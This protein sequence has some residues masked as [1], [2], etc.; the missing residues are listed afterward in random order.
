MR[1]ALKR[2]PLLARSINFCLEGRPRLP[3]YA[4]TPW[5]GPAVL[6]HVPVTSPFGLALSG[7]SAVKRHRFRSDGSFAKQVDIGAN[8]TAAAGGA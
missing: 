3:R 5:P 2:E 4:L 7:G 1:A 8:L 6:L